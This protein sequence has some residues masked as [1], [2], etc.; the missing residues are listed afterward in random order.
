[1][2]PKAPAAK[3]KA[4]FI[5]ANRLGRAQGHGHGVQ[6][7]IEPGRQARVTGF[8]PT[9]A[10]PMAGQLRDQ[11]GD[12][13]QRQKVGAVQIDHKGRQARRVLGRL[14]GPRRRR[15][16][17]HCGTAGTAFGLQLMF[18]H[19]QRG[20][21]QIEHLMFAQL[22][23][24]RRSQV[25]VA[26]AAA[27]DRMPHDVIG[28]EGRFQSVPGMPGLSARPAGALAALAARLGPGIARRRRVGGAAVAD[29]NPPPL[30]LRQLL[31]QFQDAP[32]HG[33]RSRGHQRSQICPARQ[34]PG[35]ID[36]PANSRRSRANGC[37]GKT[38][39]RLVGV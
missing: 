2:Q 20:R 7:R 35:Q 37:R 10:E 1:M 9:L 33:R 24:R 17:G 39:T 5:A 22:G 4:G 11:L 6:E 31:L 25:E 8:D 15:R 18:G 13:L 21:R 30:G 19:H 36:H 38:S 23:H 3:P 16:L 29:R 34:N 14:L 12:P 27:A 32:D 28:F 26:S